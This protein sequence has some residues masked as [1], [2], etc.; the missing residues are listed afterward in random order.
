MNKIRILIADDHKLMRMGL[1][2]LISCNDDMVCVGEASNGEEAVALARTLKPNVI[3][4]D[5]MMPKLSGATATKIIHEELPN[6]K[7]IILTSYG[8][9]RE[10][11]DAIV[12]GAHGTLMKDAETDCLVTTI[13]NVAAGK[14]AIP[15]E[16]QNTAEEDLSAGYL[17]NHQKR[18]L[19]SIAIGRTNADIAKEFGI[20]E[21]TVKNT[22]QRIF[23]CLG[24]ANRSEAISIAI[25]KHLI[26]V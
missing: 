22:L 6:S 1:V 18:I 19:S 14:T 20:A 11:S 8:T 25:R 21:S 17:T 15:R 10:M 16:L 24:A 4:M 7:I 12:N 3:I 5:L 23:T 13:R 9:S 2:S 26:S